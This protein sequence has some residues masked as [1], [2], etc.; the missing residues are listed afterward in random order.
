V[1]HYCHY[2]R[3]GWDVVATTIIFVFTAPVFLPLAIIGFFVDLAD[4]RL[5]KETA[6]D[7]RGAR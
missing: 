4:E 6:R 2:A 3:L 7:P 1:K 5:K